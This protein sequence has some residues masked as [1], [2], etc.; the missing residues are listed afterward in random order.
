MDI[1]P[2]KLKTT[3]SDHEKRL[4]RIEEK[5]NLT[6]RAQNPTWFELPSGLKTPTGQ[7]ALIAITLVVLVYLF[8]FFRR[9]FAP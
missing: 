9:Y 4:S 8:D 6:S 2:N 7:K 1:D 3:L 5:L